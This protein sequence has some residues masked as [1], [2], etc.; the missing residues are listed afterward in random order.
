MITE[1]LARHQVLKLL[2]RWHA[3]LARRLANP[4]FWPPELEDD[5]AAFNYL[6]ATLK[7]AWITEERNEP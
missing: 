7:K 4:E 6:A 2:H 5:I 1:A 3:T